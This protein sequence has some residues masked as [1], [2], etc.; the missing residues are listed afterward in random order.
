MLKI[1][2]TKAR[3]EF[4]YYS[5]KKKLRFKYNLRTGT[6]VFGWYER[7][8]HK[9]WKIT[10][11]GLEFFDIKNINKIHRVIYIVKQKNPF[12]T[13]YILIHEF[14]HFLIDILFLNNSKLHNL[15]DNSGKKTLNLIESLI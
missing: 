7:D 6:K 3:K 11:K 10:D 5:N 14:I 12:I 15:F 13:E 2:L 8:L 4:T 1:K 9:F